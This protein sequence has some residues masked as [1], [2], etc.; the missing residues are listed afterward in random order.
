MRFERARERSSSVPRP[1]T[2]RAGGR[3]CW[4][5][6]C[7]Q[8]LRRRARGRGRE[9]QH[10]GQRAVAGR[11][12]S[13]ACPAP[14]RLLAQVDA[15][16]EQPCRPPPGGAG[17]DQSSPL[18][19]GAGRPWPGA[20]ARWSA[21]AR[22]SPPPAPRGQ[23]QVPAQLLRPAS[24]RSARACSTY[25][26]RAWKRT[27]SSSASGQPGSARNATPWVSCRGRRPVAGDGQGIGLA[28][29]LGRCLAADGHVEL[30]RRVAA[31]ALGAGEQRGEP[32]TSGRA[33]RP[34]RSCAFRDADCS[35]TGESSRW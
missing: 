22:T 19:N 24:A 27:A 26:W 16:R 30:A 6:E 1:S 7:S 33:A 2:T 12:R 18:T 4:S 32:R 20:A 13:S 31:A 25:A 14:A 34:A 17:C 3:R 21:G 23:S 5:I 8:G 15:D 11:R 35:S 29:G 28:V 10:L 9:H